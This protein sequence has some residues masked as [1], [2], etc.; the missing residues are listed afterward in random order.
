MVQKEVAKRLTAQ[1][2]N[3]DYGIPTVIVQTVS[4]IEY[5]FD[6]GKAN[7]NPQPKVDSAVICMTFRKKIE[8]VEDFNLLKKIVR[9]T[10]NYRRKTLK[11]SLG[12]IFPNDIV[13]SI[14]EFDLQ[15]RPENLSVLDFQNLSNTIYNLIKQKN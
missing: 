6:V 5:L 11:N 13:N 1:N 7:F 4:N 3:K 14:A 2:G 15:L 9:G 12:R 10:F 8:N